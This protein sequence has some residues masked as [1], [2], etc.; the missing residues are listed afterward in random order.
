MGGR[1]PAADLVDG[2]R[3]QTTLLEQGVVGEHRTWRAVEQQAPVAQHQ[4]AVG[5]FGDETDVVGDHQNGRVVALAQSHH[6]SHE[7]L[8]ALVILAYRRLVED[9]Q[10]WFEHQHGGDA[11]PPAF[12]ETQAERRPVDIAGEVHDAEH[13]VDPLADRRLRHAAHRQAIG[14]LVPDA[15]GHEL[16]VGVLEHVAD[17]AEIS[18]G[19][20]ALMSL[21]LSRIDCFGA[22][23]IPMMSRASVVLPE[24]LRPHSATR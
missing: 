6:E 19:P 17:L 24:P 20:S 14:D 10:A 18:F 8:R 9:E 21:P 22:S 3:Q 1:D 16:V 15:V 7:E 12:A 4:G 13:L 2:R 23:L 5:P 11:Q